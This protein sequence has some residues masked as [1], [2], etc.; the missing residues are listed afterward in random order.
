MAPDM[1][2]KGFVQVRGN[3][4]FSPTV[5]VMQFC[6][7]VVLTSIQFSSSRLLKLF[8]KIISVVSEVSA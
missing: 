1:E 6:A 4:L 8:P 2:E 5:S 3:V 7:T